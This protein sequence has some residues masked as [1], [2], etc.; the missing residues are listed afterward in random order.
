[1]VFAIFKGVIIRLDTLILILINDSL[2]L[3]NRFG[4]VVYNDQ[5]K[6]VARSKPASGSRKKISCILKMKDAKLEG[7]WYGWKSTSAPTKLEGILLA[8]LQYLVDFS[9]NGI[10]SIH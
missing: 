5:E 1:V 7:N 2:I 3:N 8:S 6:L 9:Y 4:K 10:K